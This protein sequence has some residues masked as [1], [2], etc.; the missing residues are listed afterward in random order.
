MKRFS[1]KAK[2]QSG[3]ATSGVVESLSDKSAVRVLQERG[4]MVISISE[5][6]VWDWKNISF[7]LLGPTVTSR[8]V[9]TF[10]GLLATMISAGLPLTD[11]LDNL[12][13]QTTNS[14]FREV[15]RSII[16]DVQSGVSLSEAMGRYPQVFDA[17][18]INLVKA[19]EAS[20]KMDETLSKLAETMESNLDFKAKVKGAMIYPMVVVMAMLAIAV[21]M[22]TTI[23]PRISDVYKEFGAD[24]PLPTRILID[25]SNIVS[26]DFIIVAVVV[27]LLAYAVRTLKKNPTSEYLINNF[28]F[29]MPVMG[30]LNGEVTV[31]IIA[32]TLGM[33]LYSGVAI[34]DSLKIVAKAMENNYYRSGLLAAATLVE[35]GLPLSLAFRRDPNFPLIMTQLLAIGE[36]TGTVDQS[37]LKLA[38]FYQEITERKVKTL[39]T[40]LEPMLILLMGSMVGALAIAVLLP[41]FNLVNVIK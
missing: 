36:Q 9:T 35:K 37:L 29:K 22:L 41:M 12:S 39:T 26:N 28:M 40:L 21:F 10:T 4:L 27:L 18:Y 3:G 24:L 32:R 15:Q 25:L 6:R 33:L 2:D 13:L 1:Y 11:A 7:G 5:K 38:K 8:E 16:H 23:I 14:Y 20:G 30:A 31:T 19:G 17:L 34:L